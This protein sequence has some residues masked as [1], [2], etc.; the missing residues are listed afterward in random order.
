MRILRV[1][2]ILEMQIKKPWRGIN[3]FNPLSFPLNMEVSESVIKTEEGGF[4]LMSIRRKGKKSDKTILMLHGGGYVMEANLGHRKVAEY[5]VDAGFNLDFLDYPL[6]PEHNY[7]TTH[8]VLMEAYTKIIGEK[9]EQKIY[10]F[11]DS[12]GGGLALAFLQILRDRGLPLPEKTVL[13]SPWVDLVMKNKKIEKLD[14][15]DPV[16]PLS[17]L[18]YA[19]KVYIK[20]GNPKDPLVSPLYGTMEN[21]GDIM[22]LVGTNEL[23]YYDCL[24]LAEK[25]REAPGSEAILVIGQNQIHDWILNPGKNARD[26]LD[27]IAAFFH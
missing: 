5:F 6:A 8:K 18:R 23:L 25:L 1:K 9:A 21:L 19:A 13:A 10:L 7:K 2:K 14:E 3:A 11:G 16:L 26:T 24:T 4:K 15:I 27:E 12:A 22:V 20:D 17:G